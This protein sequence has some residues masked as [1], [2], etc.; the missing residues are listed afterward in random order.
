MTGLEDL[1]AGA[2]NRPFPRIPCEFSS[3][4]DSSMQAVGQH[5]TK[6]IVAGIVAFLPVGGL[7]LTVA[8]LV[9]LVSSSGLSRLA[10]YFPG[11]GL[12]LAVLSI[13]L[14]GLTVSTFVGK[15]GWATVDSMLNKLPALG[16]LYLSLKQILG[17]GEGDD[18]IFHETVLITSQ[19]KAGEELGLI[20]NSITMP[21]GA[22]KYVVFVPG[23]PN[24]TAGRLIITEPD[25]VR[26]IPAT[27]NDA[28][29]MLVAL[30]KGDLP[31][32]EIEQ[33]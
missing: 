6:C 26:K 28:L 22:T 2:E 32:N 4:R 18:A 17:Y 25:H 30:G 13:Y 7:I 33:S 31:V 29:R 3:Q 1:T 11:M 23:S 21:D 19:D 20:T 8:F 5:I 24:P 27:T 15:W 12:I 16:K 14:V 10:F 9:S